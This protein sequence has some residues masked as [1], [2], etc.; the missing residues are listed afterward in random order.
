MCVTCT[1]C[2]LVPFNILFLYIK[3][4]D[5]FVDTFCLF[6]FHL[7]QH[8]SCSVYFINIH[9]RLFPEVREV[10]FYYFV[11]KSS[12]TFELGIFFFYSSCTYVFFFIILC[13]ISWRFYV[14]TF[15][16]LTFSFTDISIPSVFCAWD[17]LSPLF[18]YVVHVCIYSFCSLT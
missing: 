14:R 11:K 2:P 7:V 9:G 4:F 5:Y 1:H 12:W 17:C 13:N 18:Y 16:V 8:I 15:L 10:F 6:S 3:C